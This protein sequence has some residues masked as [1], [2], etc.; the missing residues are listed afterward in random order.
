MANQPTNPASNLNLNNLPP[1]SISSNSSA[2]FTPRTTSV[3]DDSDTEFNPTPLQS[4]GGP[5]YDDLPP[6]YDE[7]RHQAVSDARQ[8]VAP[9]DPNQIEA[10]RLTLNEGPNEPEVWEYRVRGE[11]LDTANEHE[12]APEY[13]NITNDGSTTV[14]VQHVSNSESIPVGRVERA[15]STSNAARDPAADLLTRALEF[16]SHEPDADVRYAPRLARRIAV[17]QQERDPVQFSRVYAKALHAHFIQP[18]EFVEF[19]DGLNALC[20]AAGITY[21]DLLTETPITDN[22]SNIIHDYIRGA[23]EAFFA[24]RGLRVSLRSLSELVEALTVPTARGQRAGAIA[25]ALD[26]ESSV[27]TRAQALHPWIEAVETDVPAPSTRSLMLRETIERLRSQGENED[28]KSTHRGEKV[29]LVQEDEDPPH[30]GLDA[31]AEQLPGS[32]FPTDEHARNG[33]GRGGVWS[34]FGATGRG[35]FGAPGNGPFGRP[36]DPLSG[37]PG[38]GSFGSRGRGAFS[39]SGPGPGG[40]S[41]CGPSRAAD[42]N[43]SNRPGNEWAA[44]GQ[45]IGKWGEGFGKRMGDW[46]QQFGKQASVWGQNVGKEASLLGQDIGQRASGSGPRRRPASTSAQPHDTMPPS[47]DEGLAGQE[48]GVF[49]GDSKTSH[50]PPSYEANH[51]G[52]APAKDLKDDDASSISSDSSDSDL[53]SDSDSDDEAFPNTQATFLERMRSINKQTEASALKGKKTPVEIHQEHNLAIEKA[54]NE[55]IAMDRKI[56]EKMSK[57]ASRR[58]LKQKRRDIVREYRHKKRELRSSHVGKGKGKGKGKKTQEWKQ[59]KKEY[60]EKRKELKKEKIQ[61]RRDEKEGRSSNSVLYGADGDREQQ[62][63]MDAMVWVVIDN[64]DA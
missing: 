61:L 45:D 53:D 62:E 50:D 21:D 27:R 18:A 26:D 12:Q 6:S 32:H 60:K 57:R 33:R 4:P 64:L 38:R 29:G 10:H 17:P 47:Y 15:A 36:G 9:L 48:T 58:A 39:L 40:R 37:G 23:N 1:P 49:R 2:P 51:H 34:P 20:M 22:T 5:G 19:L 25:S 13:S 54:T 52:K 24:P 43:R 28:A 44:M 56:G 46:G 14:P 55:K 7:A 63:M 31:T 11:E 3:A 35:P 16:T 42:D 59:V 41:G 30:S 8:G